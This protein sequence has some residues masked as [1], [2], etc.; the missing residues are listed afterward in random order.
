MFNNKLGWEG[1][2]IYIYVPTSCFCGINTP[3]TANFKL[4]CDV[5]EYRVW[6]RCSQSVALSNQYE[7]VPV[8]QGTQKE[9]NDHKGQ[10]LPMVSLRA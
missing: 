7:L 4:P 2:L 6:K 5:S 8:H 9:K 1:A 10:T 3:T